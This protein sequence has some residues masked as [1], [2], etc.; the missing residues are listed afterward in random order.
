MIITFCGHSNYLENIEDEKWLLAYLKKIIKNKDV[1]FY[2]GGYGNF[3]N[4]ALKCVK[5][6]KNK[7]KNAQIIYVTPYLNKWLDDRSD[8]LNENYD[9]IIFPEIETAPKKLAI[10]KRNEWMVT[11]ADL[12]ISYVNVHFGG[13]YNTLLY[14]HKQKKAY[15]NLY[16]GNYEIY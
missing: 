13:A 8:Y 3:D 5:K 12:L 10:I 2:L 16:K 14:A 9:G 11:K 6:Y 15:I 7:Y 1:K 4:F